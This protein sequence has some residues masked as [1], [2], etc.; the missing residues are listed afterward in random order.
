MNGERCIAY[1]SRIR[2]GSFDFYFDFYSS[3]LPSNL[4]HC[5][6]CV[7]FSILKHQNKS[8]FFNPINILD[9]FYTHTVYSINIFHLNVKLFLDREKPVTNFTL[10]N[11]VKSNL[12]RLK[13]KVQHPKTL[14]PVFKMN[15]LVKVVY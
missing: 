9:I 6:C 14:E 8:F 11:P 2:K 15:F 5:L 1:T 4:F 12:V 10:L 7:F 3:F 13:P